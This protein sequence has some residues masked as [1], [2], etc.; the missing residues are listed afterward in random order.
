MSSSHSLLPKLPVADDGESSFIPTP[1]LSQM[2]ASFGTSYGHEKTSQPE[3]TSSSSDVSSSLLSPN[4][5]AR[6]LPIPTSST[7]RSDTSITFVD[8]QD[9]KG[10]SDFDDLPPEVAEAD[11]SIA[12]ESSSLIVSLLL[13]VSQPH[14]HPSLPR[15]SRRRTVGMGFWVRLHKE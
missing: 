9:D 1:V 7:N 4:T 12:R 5:S 10:S 3:Q 15:I 11:I 13:L 6:R 2:L 8:G 14:S